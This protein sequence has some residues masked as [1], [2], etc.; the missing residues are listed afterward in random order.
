MLAEAAAAVVL[1][2]TP[3]V[4]QEPCRVEI[5]IRAEAPSEKQRVCVGLESEG[6]YRSSCWPS[7][8]EKTH[9]TTIKNIPAGEYWVVA[10][11]GEHVARTQLVVIGEQ[12]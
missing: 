3:H 5:T 7:R 2:I 10:S 12:Q 9:T 1:S 4:C 11:F 8:G 6:W